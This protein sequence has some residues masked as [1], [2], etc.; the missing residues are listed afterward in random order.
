[1]T[2][3]DHPGCGF[4]TQDAKELETGPHNAET[5]NGPVGG[6][7]GVEAHFTT[8]MATVPAIFIPVLCA[9]MGREPEQLSSRFIAGLTGR[10]GRPAP[11]L[12]RS[13]RPG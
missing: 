6:K 8:W 4:G 11:E 13:R 10:S 3:K 2:Y 7:S 9:I 1:M 12:Q 5:G